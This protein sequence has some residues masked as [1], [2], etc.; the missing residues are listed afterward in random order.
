MV[1]ASTITVHGCHHCWLCSTVQTC[2]NVVDLCPACTDLTT[3]VDCCRILTIL[4]Q[5]TCRP[6]CQAFVP[7]LSLSTSCVMGKPVSIRHNYPEH[8]F[9][10]Y[11]ILSIRVQL[12]RVSLVQLV[13]ECS[14]SSGLGTNRNEIVLFHLPTNTRDFIVS[15][16]FA[17]RN[18]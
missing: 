2:T 9:D 5:I 3:A 10:C 6:S 4:V 17:S 12:V 13:D 8:G 14:S 11:R 7:P 16:K 1:S 18:D 15:L